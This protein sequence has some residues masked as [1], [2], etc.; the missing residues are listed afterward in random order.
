MTIT[1]ERSFLYFIQRAM[2]NGHDSYLVEMKEFAKQYDCK[3]VSYEV[4][5]CSPETFTVIMFACPEAV[6]CVI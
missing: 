6:R 1:W 4:M 2:R 5:S 3:I